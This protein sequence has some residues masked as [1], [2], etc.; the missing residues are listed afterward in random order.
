MRSRIRRMGCCAVQQHK[1]DKVCSGVRPIQGV[2]L[3]S[4]R[5]ACW[6]AKIG[7]RLHLTL[8]YWLIANSHLG[9]NLTETSSPFCDESYCFCF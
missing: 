8:F 2:Q 3:A 4:K 5:P 7:H 6:A 1:E 9:V